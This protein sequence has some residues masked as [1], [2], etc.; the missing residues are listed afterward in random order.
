MTV[1]IVDVTNTTDVSIK[2]ST[3]KIRQTVL[4]NSFFVEVEL[5]VEVITC[6]LAVVF[7]GGF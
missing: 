6:C 7:C 5:Q 2:P 1:I 3:R 4:F